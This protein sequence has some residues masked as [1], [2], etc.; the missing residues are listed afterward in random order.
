MA[1]AG[2]QDAGALVSVL[3]AQRAASSDHHHHHLS[4][5]LSKRR[6][7]YRFWGPCLCG[8]PSDKLAK[9]QAFDS[10][11]RAA[12]TGYMAHPAEGRDLIAGVKREVTGKGPARLVRAPSP[13]PGATSSLLAC[14]QSGLHCVGGRFLFPNIAKA[15]FGDILDGKPLALM[16]SSPIWALGVVRP[17]ACCR[18]P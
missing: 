5:P 3:L 8:F 4:P 16:H 6:R 10:P 14:Q 18:W 2:P 9:S 13:R 17:R 11:R 7:R 12:C 1:R 15:S